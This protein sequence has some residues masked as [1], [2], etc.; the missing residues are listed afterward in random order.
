MTASTVIWRSRTAAEPWMRDRSL[1][2]LA[3]FALELGGR[4]AL[5][6]WAPSAGQA[7]SPAG[8]GVTP[9]SVAYVH[10][11]RH[12]LWWEFTLEASFRWQ[13]H[14]CRLRPDVYQRRL[15]RLTCALGLEGVL[16]REVASL[17]HGTRALADLAVA[18]LQEP[19]LLLWEEPFY[20]MSQEEALRAVRAVE[21]E[22][23]AG[24]AL[25]AVAREAPGLADLPS[26]PRRPH[27]RRR[28]LAQ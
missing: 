27:L 9:D 26:E 2:D 23:L 14:L 25:V 28:C 3:A 5:Q 17:T 6:A 7:V 21:A 18:L 19:R 16:Q 11:G 8:T 15:H 12:D 4:A 13:A 24:M 20:Y 1:T 22:H 10:G